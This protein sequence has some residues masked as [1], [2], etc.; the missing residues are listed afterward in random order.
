MAVAVAGRL[1][2]NCVND[3]CANCVSS[4]IEGVPSLRPVLRAHVSEDLPDSI[5]GAQSD[6]L[7]S[8]ELGLIPV[9]LGQREQLLGQMLGTGLGLDHAERRR[10]GDVHAWIGAIEGHAAPG[11]EKVLAGVEASRGATQGRMRGRAEQPH[12]VGGWE[13]HQFGGVDVGG[14]GGCAESVDFLR[15]VGGGLVQHD[16][17][18]EVTVFFR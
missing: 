15:R 7:P 11:V 1:A 9:H 17:G 12:R 18:G 4:D 6:G 10:G 16:T 8:I 5:G 13:P 14:V 3:G 2:M